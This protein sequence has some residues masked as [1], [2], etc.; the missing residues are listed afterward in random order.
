M[1]TGI[2]YTV[3]HTRKGMI[4]FANWLGTRSGRAAAL[5]LAAAVAVAGAQAMPDA[6]RRAEAAA[7]AEAIFERLSPN[8]A[9]SLLMMDSARVKEP[10]IPRYHWWN[11]GLHG[12]A[13]A[14]L[15]TMF[16]QS[17]GRAATFDV[18]LERKVA[19]VISTEARAKHNIFR[20]RGMRGIYTGLTYWSPNINMLRDARWG[21]GQ[22]TFGED[23]YLAGA[24]GT[25]FVKGLQGDDPKFIKVAACA[26]HYAVHSGPEKLRHQFNVDLDGRDLYEYYLPAFRTLVVDGKVEQVMGA[27]S[28]VNGVPCCANRTLLTDI[29][30]GEWGFRGTVVSDVGAVNDIWKFHKYKPNKVEACLAAVAAGLDVCSE[31]TYECLRAEVREG[32]VA[33][34]QLRAP[35]VR[36]LTTRILLGNIGGETTPW[37]GLGAK[38]VA[39]AESKALALRAAEESIV[40]LKNSGVLPLDRAKLR[41]V[42]IRGRYDE[43]APL[44]G[45]YEG[46]AGEYMTGHAGLAAELGP[47]VAVGT[48]FRDYTDVLIAFIGLTPADEGEFDDK[49]GCRIAASQMEMLRTMRSRCRRRPIVSVVYGGSPMELKEV[50]EL[51]DAVLLAWYPGEQ[52]G[53]AIARTLIG[54]S[55][56]AGRLPVTFM[57]DYSKESDIKDYSLPGRTYIYAAKKP[58]FPFG[59]GLSYT[60]FAYS[61]AKAEKDGDG[62][63]FQVE[64]SNTGKVAG[65]EVVQL[66]VRSPEG[67]GDRR[68]HHLEGFRR[69]TLGPGEKKAV[70]F[71]LRPEQIMQFGLDGKQSLAEGEYTFFAGGG[72]PGFDAGV[73]SARCAR[74]CK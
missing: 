29:L 73:V 18:D 49:A 69:V 11:E 50:C 40:L 8:E 2:A 15:A 19:E 72:Q 53:R 33:K 63:R 62:V 1:N 35:V 65:D 64:V 55:N 36:I 39:T 38:D 7:R 56:P 30:R 46:S 13:R 59:Y 45:N 48:D 52:G 31:E 22:E 67:C 71:S 27:Y 12:V 6:A 54:L 20:A 66:Y 60:T 44:V 37:D 4:L 24:M 57:E 43:A 10:A 23:P 17:I 25:A 9:V 42:M 21:R 47:G 74:E 32:R 34:E 41:G 28:A 16:P 68:V 5:A 51:S 58:L 61:G 26:K 3:E 70:A 14:G